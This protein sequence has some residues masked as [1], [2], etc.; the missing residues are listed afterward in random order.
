MAPE[1]KNTQADRDQDLGGDADDEEDQGGHKEFLVAGLKE[2]H[3][4]PAKLEF[5]EE[6]L[7]FSSVFFRLNNQ[8]GD[9]GGRRPVVA[10]L[11]HSFDLFFFP[12]ENGT[13]GSVGKIAH[14]AGQ[15]SFL[16]FALG[17]IAEVHALNNSFNDQL[18]SRFGHRISPGLLS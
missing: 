9:L 18:G 13:H 6:G 3:V 16:S 10:P 4:R 7:K 12:L 17:I 11:N 14:P 5:H 2:N 8:L 1:K 15:V